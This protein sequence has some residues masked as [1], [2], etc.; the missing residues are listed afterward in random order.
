[1]PPPTSST[2][3]STTREKKKLIDAER[4]S[5]YETL[6]ERSVR[7]EL[8]YGCITQAARKFQC[9]C[10]TIAIVWNRGRLSLR[11][12]RN[13]NRKCV[14]TDEE[15]EHAV[16]LVPLQARQ[17]MRTLA[18]QSGVMKTTI[19][20]QMQRA[21]P[22]MRKTSH[23]KPYLTDANALGRVQYALSFIKPTSKGTIFDS[24]HAHVDEK[25]SFF[26]TVKKRY[27]AYEDEDLPTRQFKFNRYITK[28]M[29]LAAVARP[30]YDYHNKCI[31]DG[32]IG[33][34]PFVENVLAKENSRNRPKC[35]PL[36]VPQTVTAEVYLKMI[37]EK[38]VPAIQAKMPRQDQSKIIYL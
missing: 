20:R 38:V 5:I 9:T 21:K 4:H 17:T 13:T 35:T 19:I 25:C 31:F 36:L 11:D 32:K 24:M 15:I 18:A 10:K 8:P 28:V 12:G 33:V 7:G 29:F 23:S 30:R 27:Y 22:L 34:W 16:K 3:S 6:L 26:T 37:L 14:L 1:M 2:A